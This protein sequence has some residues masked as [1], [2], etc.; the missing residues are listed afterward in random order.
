MITQGVVCLRRENAAAFVGHTQLTEAHHTSD[1]PDRQVENAPLVVH[2]G[3]RL[4]HGFSL[5]RRWQ[6]PPS[7]RSCKKMQ[8]IVQI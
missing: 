4:S 7:L 8:K 5:W 6:M 2:A 1:S 3:Q